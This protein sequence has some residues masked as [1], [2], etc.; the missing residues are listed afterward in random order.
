[1]NK[2]YFVFPLALL[3]CMPIGKSDASQEKY[4][5]STIHFSGVKGFKEIKV[6]SCFYGHDSAVDRDKQNG[7]E[8][9]DY[10]VHI[11]KDGDLYRLYSGGRWY[12]PGVKYGDGDH[13]LQHVSKTGKA[14]TWKMLYDRPEFW[15]GDEDGETDKWYSN[16]Y[17]EPEVLKIDGKYYMYTQLMILPGMP[18]DIPGQKAITQCDRIQ[19]HTSKDGSNWTRWSKD[20]GVVINIDDPTRINLHHQE[21][22]YVPWDR[23]KKPWWLYVGVDRNGAWAGYGRIRSDDPTTFDWRNAEWSVGLS[24]IGNQIAY[25]K[26]APGGPLF[27]RITFT[28][29]GTG[30]QVPS[31]QFSR[32]GLSWI[33]GDDGPVKLDGSKDNSLNKNC[34]F[35]GISTINGTGELEYPGDNTFRAIYGASTIN[36]PDNSANIWFSEIGVGELIFRIK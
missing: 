29:D 21:V 1:M 8:V 13:V 34:Y 26:Q 5:E 11:I 32:D 19:L 16:N 36:S 28:D 33:W 4:K 3:F 31:L 24:Q 35:L 9:Y 15:K 7:V 2:K 10:S 22:I 23:D 27:V 18:I 6:K 17:L 30:R 25:A 20:R 14:G 12:R